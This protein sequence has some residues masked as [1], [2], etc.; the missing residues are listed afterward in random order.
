MRR[1]FIALGLLLGCSDDMPHTQGTVVERPEPRAC[2]AELPCGVGHYDDAIG[3]CVYT[4][5]PDGTP[6]ETACL[7]NASCRAGRCEGAPVDC[8]DSDPCT[9]DTCS[10]IGCTHEPVVCSAPANPCLVAVCDPDTGCGT[11]PVPDGVLCGPP[12]CDTRAVCTGGICTNVAAADG[13]ACDG[14]CGE[15]VCAEGACVEPEVLQPSWTLPAKRPFFDDRSGALVVPL[16]ERSLARLSLDGTTTPLSI[17]GPAPYA[18]REHH[19]TAVG[20][21]F[22]TDDRP[23]YA[24]GLGNTY[25][26]SL[27]RIDGSL[28]E[29]E[30]ILANGAV[31]GVADMSLAWIEPDGT[32]AW[33]RTLCEDDGSHGA[34]YRG[35][36]SDEDGQVYFMWKCPQD[37]RLTL[38]R[39][40]ADGSLVLME[41]PDGE[42]F[43]C[44]PNGAFA[45]RLSLGCR[46][47]DDLVFDKDTREILPLGPGYPNALT[48]DMVVMRN[49]AGGGSVRAVRIPDGEV[50]WSF[51]GK[52]GWP[53]CADD[54]CRDRMIRE[55]IPT[56]T[57]SVLVSVASV[58]KKRWLLEIARDGT[59]LRTCRLPDAVG[60]H[61]KWVGLFDGVWLEE[62]SDDAGLEGFHLSGRPQ[63]APGFIGRDGSPTGGRRPWVPVA[64][65]GGL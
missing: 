53:G 2:A 22:W 34:M 45:G 46:P 6:C 32:V 19:G 31:V 50:L 62:G 24:T 15:G 8:A 60:Q 25:T 40:F 36:M 57:G 64:P 23:L 44:W 42:R 20:R 38:A 47:G 12:A 35:G 63:L 39:V 4:S 30:V 55:A 41:R 51:Y 27:E 18:F 58:W 49:P 37:E 21:W 17:D 29:P 52:D 11:A 54:S 3:G 13:D 43:T 1:L 61:G 28:F 56:A 33:V 59:L 5:A 7:E 26:W 9:E 16:G 48:A 65:A 14:V 10:S